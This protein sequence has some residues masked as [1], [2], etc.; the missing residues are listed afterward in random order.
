MLDWI[1]S[2]RREKKPSTTPIKVQ[3]S[4]REQGDVTYVCEFSPDTWSYTTMDEITEAL[5]DQLTMKQ[6]LNGGL[7]M[8]IL[9]YET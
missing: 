4:S 1:R 2:L 6:N 5:A 7:L 8:N 9:L 3:V